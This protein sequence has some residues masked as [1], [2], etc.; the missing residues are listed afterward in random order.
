MCWVT[1]STGN[2]SHYFHEGVSRGTFLA[3]T[4]TVAPANWLLLT[5]RPNLPHHTGVSS[6]WHAMVMPNSWLAMNMPHSWHAM[7]MP[8]SSLHSGSQDTR[9]FVSRALPPGSASSCLTLQ[10]WLGAAVPKKILD[11]SSIGSRENQD[12][13]SSRPGEH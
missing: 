7:L 5:T 12:R 8:H 10:V 13:G 3:L 2:S 9:A 4:P 1:L 6:S 11:N